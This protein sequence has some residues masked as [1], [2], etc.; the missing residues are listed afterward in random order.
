MSDTH[1]KSGIGN[2]ES[3]NRQSAIDNRRLPQFSSRVEPA[4]R[5]DRPGAWNHY[6]DSRLP[7][8]DSSIADGRFPIAD[9]KD[10]I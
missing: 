9:A 4:C 8:P 7:I 1:R 3:K 6:L 10:T 2:R 5:P